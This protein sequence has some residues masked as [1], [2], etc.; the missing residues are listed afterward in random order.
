[1]VKKAR[2]PSTIII[3]IIL[4][5]FLLPSDIPIHFHFLWEGLTIDKQFPGIYNMLKW[6]FILL[7]PLELFIFV[8]FFYYGK[9]PWFLF[10]VA[11]VILLSTF[12]YWGYYNDLQSRVTLPFLFSF[13]LYLL[14]ILFTPQISGIS[15]KN[16][17]LG[18]KQLHLHRAVIIVLIVISIANSTVLVNIIE[19]D[20]HSWSPYTNEETFLVETLIT[21]AK[22]IDLKNKELIKKYPDYK[23][24][25]FQTSHKERLPQ[26]LNQYQLKDPPFYWDWI[27][28]TK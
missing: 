8:I 27:F 2:I 1:M 26:L 24:K 22:N 19:A 5:S 7:I 3:A 21:Q 25:Y 12:T 18:I 10:S 16:A 20:D 6:W 23:E 28:R 17:I 9:D 4:S 13:N 11:G 14:F 15:N